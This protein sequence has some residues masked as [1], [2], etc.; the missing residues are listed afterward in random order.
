MIKSFFYK[1]RIKISLFSWDI[2]VNFVAKSILIP[3][4]LRYLIYR[5]AGMRVKSINI[6]SECIFRGK[7][8][9]ISEGVLLNNNVFID[10]YEKVYIEKNTSIAFGTLICTSS[11]KF[12]TS[13]KR[14][15]ESDRRPIFIGEGCWIGAN[16]TIL[17]GVTIGDGCIIGAGSLV[18]KNCDS[19]SLY[20]GVPAVKIRS[21]DKL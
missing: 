1:I 15:G 17:P 14:A 18:N 12:G 21:L 2:I 9:F 5:I 4:K 8:V 11:H 10:A 3:R 19:N 20:L 7:S 13:E 6:R 16:C